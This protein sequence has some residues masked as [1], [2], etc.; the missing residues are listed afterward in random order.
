[1]VVYS[2]CLSCLQVAQPAPVLTKT[3]LRLWCLETHI[4]ETHV[5]HKHP[6]LYTNP[7]LHTHTSILTHHSNTNLCFKLTHERTKLRYSKCCLNNQLLYQPWISTP[8]WLTPQLDD[9]IGL[10][11]TCRHF[12]PERSPAS[13]EL[14]VSHFDQSMQELNNHHPMS[15][16]TRR[17]KFGQSNPNWRPGCIFWHR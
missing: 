3:Y 5:Y 4:A 1:M 13:Q 16:S 6:H 9:V 7:D 10:F 11:A 15:G 2:R 14:L 17:W 12:Q 8:N